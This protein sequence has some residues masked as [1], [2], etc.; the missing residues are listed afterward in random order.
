[1]KQAKLL[2]L[3]GGFFIIILFDLFSNQN[4]MA[5]NQIPLEDFFKNPEK[6]S[7]QISPDGKY[8]SYMAPYESRMNIFVQKVGKDKATRLT[9][10]TDR[11]IAGYYWANPDRI[12][13]LKDDGGNEDFA[14]YGVDKNGKNLKCL[15]CFEGVRTQIIDDLEDIPD[16]IIIGLNKRTPQVFDP[17]R[18]NI[19]SGEMT[20]LA[21]N[22][23]NIQG[24]MTDH[25]GKLRVAIAIVDGINSQIQYRETEDDEFKP[26]LTTNFKETVNPAFFD[27]ENKNVYATSNLGRDKQVVV[28]FDIAN[29]KELEVLYENEDYDVGGVFYSRKRKVLTS[30]SYTSWKRERHFFDA[31]T[32]QLFKNLEQ[33]L[34]DY[35]LG[36]SAIS[37]DE[38]MYMVRTY[39]DRS[40][41][42]Y[43][44]YNKEND[45]LDKIHDVSPWIDENIMANVYPIKYT[46][47]DGLVIPG[48]I[49]LPKG[50]TLETAKN[51]PMVINPHGGPWARDN[52]GFNPE[53]QFLAN[54]GYGVLQMNFR[55]STGYGREFMEKSFKQWGL[56]MQNDITDGVY[57]LINQG[58]ADKDKVAIYGGSYGGYATLQGV[59]VT[60][61]LYA[62][63]IDY[64][65]VSNLFSFM[66]T[67]PPYWEPYLDM[68]YEMVGNPVADS[69][70]FTATSPAL[71]A[72]KIMTPLFVAQG[73]NDPRVN[74]AESDQIVEA[75]KKRGI[76]VEYL[77][78]D[79]EGHGFRNEENRF[80]FYR[81]MEKF[82]DAHL[83]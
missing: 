13:Y 17:Y 36:I 4:V 45:Q 30:V 26:V 47:R 77:V 82:L 56:E 21:E 68:M 9:S 50:L 39:S 32:E 15:T 41:G 83:K 28:L 74:I 55:G 64:V 58:I 65:G 34:G 78:K 59:V 7:Y 46:A 69:V 54:R 63:A 14:V 72:D 80:D 40:L 42:A 8:F 35:E 29:G 38:N 79:N 31:E 53:I 66:K 23:G 75:L 61:T 19:K 37:K 3:A 73:A 5:Q 24:W 62:A 10:E 57:W 1:M 16:E 76:E 52:W 20:M 18:L 44:L 11:D 43:F 48:Y 27:F 25:E 49:T 51:L 12:L 22:P 81:A 60:P 67:I 6:T 70:Q 33:K 2:M 71:N